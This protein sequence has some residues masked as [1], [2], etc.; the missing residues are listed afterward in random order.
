M[1]LFVFITNRVDA[2]TPIL[3]KM[4]ER[5]IHG[6]TMVDCAGML[7]TLAADTVEP[8]PFFISLRKFINPDHEPG[9]MLFVVLE[10]EQVGIAKDTI[11]E[12]CGN[13]DRPNS[14]VMFTVPVTSVEGVR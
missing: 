10:E 13:L 7:Q 3:Q 1:L 5:N 2:L 11:H 8:P 6:A 12:V 4:A 9:K 14:G